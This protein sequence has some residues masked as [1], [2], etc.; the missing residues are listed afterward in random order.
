MSMN[1]LT[2]TVLAV[3]GIAVVGLYVI[4]HK[5]EEF[6][7]AYIYVTWTAIIAVVGASVYLAYAVPTVASGTPTPHS[8]T[9]KAGTVTVDGSNLL[10]E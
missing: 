6:E 9:A 1:P 2:I 10:R 8:G 4:A 5:F 3:L 7:K